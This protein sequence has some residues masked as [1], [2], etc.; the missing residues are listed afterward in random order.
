MNALTAGHDAAVQM[1][2]TSIV[3]A[4][5]AEGRWS[6]VFARQ[7]LPA[8]DQPPTCRFTL[9]GARDL[10]PACCVVRRVSP[11][12]TCFLPLVGIRSKMT[13]IAAIRLKRFP[14][15]YTITKGGCCC[16]PLNSY[17]FA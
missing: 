6:T 14:Y 13:P 7:N 4:C 3:R 10:L 5:G 16:P 15:G 9:A 1:I 17:K 8:N 2:D 12:A 11:R